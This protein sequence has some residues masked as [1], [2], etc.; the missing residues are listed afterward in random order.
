MHKL[1]QLGIGRPST[2]ASIV[3]VLREREYVA[4]NERR[5]VPLERKRVVTVFHE[6]F[7]ARWAAYGFTA[8]LE[9]D[10]DRIAAGA[11]AWKAFLGG[12]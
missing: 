7:F 3:G 11:L 5:F 8:G 10:L 6:A 4:L 1:E 2:Y 9:R 12:F